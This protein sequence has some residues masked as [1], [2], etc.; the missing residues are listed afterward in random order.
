MTAVLPHHHLWAGKHPF[1]CR[2]DG[3]DVPVDNAVQRVHWDT[4]ELRR[5]YEGADAA[6]VN[7]ELLA[8][9][10]RTLF[11]RLRIVQQCHVRPESMF[12]HAWDAA[13]LVTVL[14]GYMAE[15][16]RMQTKTKVSVWPMAYDERKFAVQ[17]PRGR[18]VDVFFVHRCSA[19]NYTHHE[20]FL[21]VASSFGSVVYADVTKYLRIRRPEL[22]YAADADFVHT[23]FRSKAVVALQDDGYGGVAV[24]EAARA[25]C[26]VV[27]LNVPGYRDLDGAYFT[28]L[29]GLEAAVLLALKEPR[30]VDVSSCSYQAALPTVLSDMEDLWRR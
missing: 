18:D 21:R 17:S 8:V 3:V 23:M 15:M 13:D 4:R 24:R 27:A 10:L 30:T 2:T 12:R 5:V 19:S 11:P 29:T 1:A 20:E 14:G 28:D 6:V 26:T 16:V 9:P 25:G 22:R 7:S